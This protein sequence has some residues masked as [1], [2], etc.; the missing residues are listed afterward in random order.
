M[1]GLG[2]SP[3]IKTEFRSLI[4]QEANAGRSDTTGPADN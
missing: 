2:V 4:E 1:K 3:K